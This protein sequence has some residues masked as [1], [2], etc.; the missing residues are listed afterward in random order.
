L[1]RVTKEQQMNRAPHKLDV[2]QSADPPKTDRNTEA[3]KECPCCGATPKSGMSL[4]EAQRFQ[5]VYRKEADE[6]LHG[7]H[8]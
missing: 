8:H 5:R 3:Q 1:K 4:I 2:Q 7:P 6:F